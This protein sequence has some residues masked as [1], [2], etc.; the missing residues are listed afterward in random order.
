[1]PSLTCDTPSSTAVSD[2]AAYEFHNK[3]LIEEF[4]KK[5]HSKLPLHQILS[6]THSKRRM[7]ISASTE[8]I[9]VFL[10]EYLLV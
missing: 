5:T 1:M 8:K 2:N 10:E 7:C 6:K 4:S 9:S 3:K